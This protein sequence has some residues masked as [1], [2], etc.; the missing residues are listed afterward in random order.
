MRD[1]WQPPSCLII[2]DPEILRHCSD[3]DEECVN[4]CKKFSSFSNEVLGCVAIRWWILHAHIIV[5]FSPSLKR[6]LEEAACLCA[7]LHA[8]NW[9]TGSA[10]IVTAVIG[11]G[12]L[13]LGWSVAQVT[14]L[15][16]C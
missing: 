9:R 16:H 11:S 4:I 7:D 14:F 13:S 3:S 5:Y 12:V 1:I 10:H 6:I 15:P 2:G 8:G